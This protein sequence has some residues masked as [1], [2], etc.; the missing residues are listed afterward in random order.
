MRAAQQQVYSLNLRIEDGV[1]GHDAELHTQSNF[2]DGLNLIRPSASERNI[3]GVTNDSR[4]FL[5]QSC[6]RGEADRFRV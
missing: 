5:Y 2:R 4:P 3:Y 1:G 6:L